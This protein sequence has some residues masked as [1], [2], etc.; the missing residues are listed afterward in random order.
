MNTPIVAPLLAL[1]RSR[2]V[3][4]SVIVFLVAILVQAV[5]ALAPIAGTL[6]S[7][8]AIFGVAVISG[9][10]IEDAAKYVGQRGYPPVVPTDPQLTP[11]EAL[12]KLINDAID[13]RVNPAALTAPSLKVVAPAKFDYVET[14]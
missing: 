3:I 10:S 14:N 6:T 5:P 9:I 11:E 4:V 12:R 7:V 13:E 8:L 2:K 1:L